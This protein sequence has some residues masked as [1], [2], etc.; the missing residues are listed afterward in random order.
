MFSLIHTAFLFFLIFCSHFI[1]LCFYHKISN[2]LLWFELLFSLIIIKA[3]CHLLT[4]RSSTK[5]SPNLVARDI[6]A[7]L[8][9]LFSGCL[10]SIISYFKLLC[11]YLF[12]SFQVNV[13]LLKNQSLERV[14]HPERLKYSVRGSEYN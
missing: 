5:K 12:F 6:K 7:N 9:L 14:E 11:L 4:W 2:L 3:D 1:S 8:N 10:M 13:P